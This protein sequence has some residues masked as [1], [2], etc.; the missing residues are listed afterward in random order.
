M[1]AGPVPPPKPAKPGQNGNDENKGFSVSAA[2]ALFEAAK[3]PEVR[4]A[5]VAAAKNPY[6]RATAKNVAENKEARNAVLTAVSNPSAENKFSAASA[7]YDA[8]R[9]PPP[10]HRNGSASVSAA[11]SSSGKVASSHQSIISKLENLNFGAPPAPNPSTTAAPS[12]S[13]YVH[14]S[15][16]QSQQPRLPPPSHSSS[17]STSSWTP[18]PPY[19]SVTRSTPAVSAHDPH[20]TVKYAFVG[21]HIDELTCNPGEVVLL[22]RHVDD[23]WIYGMNTTTGKHGIVPQSYLQVE[24]PLPA[25]S[26]PKSTSSSFASPSSGT[27]STALYDYDS[28]TPGDLRFRVNDRILVTSRVNADWLE[29]ELYGQK[30]I[31]PANFVSLDGSAPAPVSAP[32][33]ANSAPTRTKRENVTAAYDYYSGVASDLQFNQG[34]VIEVVEKVDCDWI[35]GELNGRRGLVPVTFL[36]SPNSSP[37]K[38]PGLANLS[39]ALKPKMAV[40]IADYHS[41]DPKHLYV[42]RG[43]NIIISETVD[44]YYYKGKLEAFKTLPAGIFPKNVVNVIEN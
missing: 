21:A 9:P 23:Q 20:A 30:G 17:S 37:K 1:S 27:Y 5:V 33:P 15:S 34:D 32:A 14:T 35:M 26:V 4:Q 29:G 10:P 19:N 22:K 6:V 43:D 39:T 3:K 40:A 8:N 13:L 11:S 44:E 42:T 31:F 7:V 28:A 36:L 16:S 24:V 38:S 2:K 41:D 12:T 18:A 25:E